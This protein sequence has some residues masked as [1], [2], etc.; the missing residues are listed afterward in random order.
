MDTT[1]LIRVVCASILP[2]L[3]SLSFIFV[4][5][6]AIKE[7]NDKLNRPKLRPPNWV[8]GPVW[9]FLYVSMGYASYLVW[10]DGGGFSGVARGPLIFYAALLGMN[11]AWS[12]IFFGA[13]SVK[14]VIP[15]NF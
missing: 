2:N 10:R 15:Q 6:K 11:W 4:N 13:R 8:F 14:W 3:G 7:W 5:N 12:P 1:E 9:T